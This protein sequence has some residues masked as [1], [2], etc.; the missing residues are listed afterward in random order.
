[1]QHRPEHRRV[2]GDESVRT[3]S[4]RVEDRLGCPCVRDALR[5]HPVDENLDAAGGVEQQPRS[6][7]VSSQGTYSP[8]DACCQVG[9]VSPS[10]SLVRASTRRRC[11]AASAV[12]SST[13]TSR[14]PVSAARPRQPDL[15]CGT[16]F[17]ASTTTG[18]PTRSV[19]A[20]TSCATA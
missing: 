11:S 8:C 18:V 16:G 12:V 4:R 2:P 19:D 6:V 14:A 5:Q 15:A 20:A 7:A 9:T 3:A 10:R 1:M 17:T 13:T